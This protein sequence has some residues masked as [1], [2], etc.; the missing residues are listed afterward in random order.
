MISTSPPTGRCFQTFFEAKTY[1]CR[2]WGQLSQ[3]GV[4]FCWLHHVLLMAK[5]DCPGM[6]IFEPHP[7]SWLP[8][9]N[10]QWGVPGHKKWSSSW[11]LDYF[12]WK[13]QAFFLPA[14]ICQWDRTYCSLEQGWI[15]PLELWDSAAGCYCSLCSSLLPT[16]PAAPGPL[17]LQPM[18]AHNSKR[19][20]LWDK[21]FSTFP[22][23]FQWTN[24]PNSWCLH[25]TYLPGSSEQFPVID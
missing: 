7:S 16:S 25:S 19:V 4:Q 20:A 5:G 22:V 6:P 13:T 23:Y 3:A 2:T 14:S 15:W 11:G 18:Y 12:T 24:K 10:C 9:E 1:P 17:E 8:R 21:Y